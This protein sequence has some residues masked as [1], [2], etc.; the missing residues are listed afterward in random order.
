VHVIAELE[1]EAHKKQII[2]E[3]VE[4]NAARLLLMGRW[5]QCS[6]YFDQISPSKAMY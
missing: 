3:F 4:D 5:L 2:I 6:G 1:P